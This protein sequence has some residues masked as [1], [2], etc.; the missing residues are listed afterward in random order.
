V[1]ELQMLLKALTFLKRKGIL[2]VFENRISSWLYGDH[3]RWM[4]MYFNQGEAEQEATFGCLS[5]QAKC[6]AE[7]VVKVLLRQAFAL[8]YLS[9]KLETLPGKLYILTRT[10]AITDFGVEIG[11]KNPPNIPESNNVYACLKGYFSLNLNVY[12]ND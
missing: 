2:Q 12:R 1:K 6:K 8:E 5:S 7:Q 4:N 11:N 10:W 9:L 3:E